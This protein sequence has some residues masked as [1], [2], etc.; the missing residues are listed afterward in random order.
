MWSV[1][2]EREFRESLFQAVLEFANKQDGMVSRQDVSEFNFA[3]ERLRLI[4][5]QGG[6]WNPSASWTLTDP[7]RATLS[8]N[9]TLSGIYDDQEISGGL[10]RYD[11]QAGG[12]EGK[13]TK[14]RLAWELQLPVLWLRQQEPSGRYVPYIVFVVDDFPN[15]NYCFIAPDLSLSMTIKTGNEIERKYAERLM[16][17]RLH[18]PAFRARVLNAYKVRCA[19]CNLQFGELLEGAHI[20]PDSDPDSSTAVSNGISLCK[21]HHAAYDRE[22]MGIDTDFVVQVRADILKITDG[23]MLQYGLQ[24]MHER[25]LILPDLEFNWPDKVRLDQRYSKFKKKEHGEAG[26]K[27]E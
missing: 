8:I 12:S 16:K 6:I 9:T 14:L 7:L 5:P 4:D 27:Y 22:F 19:V 21:M 11:Y 17:Q 1:E 15:D 13:N 20:T 2:E 24:K 25:E 23:P 10:W 26:K 3:G 18:Q